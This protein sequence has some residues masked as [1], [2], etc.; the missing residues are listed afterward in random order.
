MKAAITFFLLNIH[1]NMKFKFTTFLSLT[2]LLFALAAQADNRN[3]LFIGNSYTG[4]N[5]LPNIVQ[6]ISTSM[7]DTLTYESYT[8][9]G[10]TAMGHWNDATT[11]AKIMQG[12]WD[13]VVIQFQSQE[14]SFSPSQVL[15]D[16]YPYAKSLDSLVKASNS[17]A[18]V[19]YY[20]TWGR[21]NGDAGNCPF[22]PP[23][24]TYNG[25][26]QRLRES[27]LLFANDFNS[28]ASPVGVAWKR[29]RDTNPAVNL[30]SADESHPSI[31]GSFLA[32]CVFYSSIFKK[33]C[34]TNQY[35][36]AGVTNS[37][38]VTMQTIATNTVLDSMENWFGKS[39]LPQASFTFNRNQFAVQFS[40]N[41]NCAVLNEWDFGDGS[42]LSNA[43]NPSHT[44]P[45]A[46][47][48]FNV[49]LR[50]TSVHGTKDTV[51]T[52]IT[53]SPLRSSN[54]VSDEKIK[55]NQIH[56]RVS[57]ENKLSDCTAELYDINGRKIKSTPL[58]KGLSNIT[59]EN[60][61]KGIYI[62]QIKQK[63]HLLKMQKVW[64]N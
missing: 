39:Q 61:A 4:V 33:S 27:Y 63:G 35:L 14:P 18:E 58:A 62:L 47:G 30:Y 43:T 25:M 34:T 13:Y 45:T 2:L 5:N 54:I 31:N 8:P 6:G 11:K 28:S 23:V 29:M 40:N 3:V 38:M 52:P 46:G 16:T 59:L 56:N 55:I 10:K 20:M 17:C 26:Q 64:A 51:C 50:V 42:A 49:C 60:Y 36:P 32:A 57:I 12:G 7:G 1:P 37:D 44:F 41:S 19:L 15:N 53:F 48:T 24:C 9:G 22:Y 21:K